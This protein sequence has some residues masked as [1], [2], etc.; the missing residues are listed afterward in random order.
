MKLM[1]LYKSMRAHRTRLGFTMIELLVVIAILGILAAT[2]LAA[3]NPVEAINRGR[4]NAVRADAAKLVGA[5]DQFY[6][7]NLTYPWLVTSGSYTA[8]T[9]WTVDTAFT[10][11]INNNYLWLSAAEGTGEMKAGFRQALAARAASGTQD[12]L[13]FKPAGAGIGQTTYVCFIPMSRTVKQEAADNCNNGKTPGGTNGP[14]ATGAPAAFC[15]GTGPWT[16]TTN[17]IYL[18]LP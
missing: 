13:V 16:N 4:D 9:G 17:N 3:I 12:L 15:P 2:V 14:P 1:N 6:V 5:I 11:G 7:S 10:A 18:C 8:P